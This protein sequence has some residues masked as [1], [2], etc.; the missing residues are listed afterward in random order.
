MLNQ[1]EGGF[2]AEW[3]GRGGEGKGEWEGAGGEGGGGRGRDG[4]GGK[5]SSVRSWVC[6]EA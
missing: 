5:A 3:G 2:V 6:F 1:L 4:E